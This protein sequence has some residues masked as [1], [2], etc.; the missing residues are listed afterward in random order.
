MRPTWHVSIFLLPGPGVSKLPSA[1][2]HVRL[3]QNGLG[4]LFYIF[5]LF[6]DLL[7]IIDINIVIVI[8]V[9]EKF[10]CFVSF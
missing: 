2:E 10:K 5:F 3:S 9:A 4:K 1:N 8:I 6:H 7:Q